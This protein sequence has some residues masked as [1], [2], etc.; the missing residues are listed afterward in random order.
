MPA[1]PGT[2]SMSTAAIVAGPS[3]WM[4]C[5]RCCSA[6]S[7]SCSCVVD[8]NDVRYR[9][10]PKKCTCPSA[11]SFG[12]RRGSPVALIAAPVLPW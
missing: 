11:Y 10:G 6:R 9:Y 4:I 2:L 7:D 3:N 1:V 5:S 12:Q 8:Q